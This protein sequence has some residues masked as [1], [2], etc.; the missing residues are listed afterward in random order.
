MK[1]KKLLVLIG[2]LTL[3]FSMNLNGCGNSSQDSSATA[4]PPTVTLEIPVASELPNTEA[5]QKTEA[6]SEPDTAAAKPPA[7]NDEANA[8]SKAD[9]DTN[10]TSGSDVLEGYIEQIDADSFIISK[11]FTR[12]EADGTMTAIS[13]GKDA[14]DSDK[15]LITVNFTDSTKFII[16]T[17]VNGG[18]SPADSSNA[19][20]SKDDLTVGASVNMKGVQTESEFNASEVII[21][22]FN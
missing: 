5:P 1:R 6:P 17:V 18:V 12:I 14:A 2:A 11:I 9:P 3:T 19:A 10:T 4:E 8:D 20:A 7:N 15:T 21:Y 16:T 22:H 13:P